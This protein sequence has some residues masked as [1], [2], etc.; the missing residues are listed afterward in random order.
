MNVCAGTAAWLSACR[1]IKQEEQKVNSIIKTVLVLVI[2]LI[3]G[4]LQA[5]FGKIKGKKE[6]TLEESGATVMRLP[7]S[8]G[9]LM[10]AVGIFLFVFI[11]IF[12]FLFLMTVSEKEMAE[13]GGM[14]MVCEA[15]A[16]FILLL[17]VLFSYC[18]RANI[19]AF[20]GIK[21][22][23]CKVFRADQEI[24]WETVG[25]IQIQS[26]QC[27]LCDRNQKILIRVNEQLDNFGHFCRVAREKMEESGG[28]VSWG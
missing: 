14:M 24:L 5:L 17:C 21:I 2:I 8:G 25:S 27:I 9:S 15:L 1:D 11:N 26:N 22:T 28:R 3:A 13:A 6:K 16:I 7:Q 10:L 23:I 19:I 18:V 12:V 4:V 20:D